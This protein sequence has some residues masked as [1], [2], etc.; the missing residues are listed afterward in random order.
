LNHPSPVQRMKEWQS[1][2][3]HLF[4]KKVY[5]LAGLDT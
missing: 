3:P 1:S 5:H 2:H 4:R